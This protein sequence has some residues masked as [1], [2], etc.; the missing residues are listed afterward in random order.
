MLNDAL[1][2]Y[3]TYVDTMRGAE[4]AL[5]QTTH[6]LSST[7]RPEAGEYVEQM[8]AARDAFTQLNEQEKQK[9]KEAITAAFDEVRAK[10]AE[11]ATV[12][13]PQELVTLLQMVE[14]VEHSDEEKQLLYDKC[15]GNYMAI[16]KLLSVVKYHENMQ[17]MRYE[18]IKRDVDGLEETMV[19]ALDVHSFKDLD[20]NKA[21]V[22]EGSMF[23]RADADISAFLAQFTEAQTV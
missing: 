20:Y 11:A 6:K 3:Q 8:K 18:D 14:G 17:P 21:I 1:K 22:Y 7:Y 19:S 15:K 5:E 16:R 12:Q 10:V 2:T 4:E 9:A 13:T 23:N